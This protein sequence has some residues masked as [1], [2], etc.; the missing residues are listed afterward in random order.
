MNVKSIAQSMIAI[1]ATGAILN[2]GGSGYLGASVQKATNF[3][4]KGYGV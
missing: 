4:T 3:I 2:L 1:V